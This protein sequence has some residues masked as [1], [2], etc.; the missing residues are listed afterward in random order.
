MY[1]SEAVILSELLRE[2]SLISD[3]QLADIAEEHER[4][5]KPFSQIIVD[6]GLMTEE[7]LLQAV[8]EH[9][10]FEFMNLEQLDLQPTLLRVMPSSVARMYGAVPVAVQ[11]NTVT[12]AVLDPY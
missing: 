9:L 10:T 7:Q 12:V 6:F 2:R 8:A 3:A 5:G 4:T 11:G 1:E